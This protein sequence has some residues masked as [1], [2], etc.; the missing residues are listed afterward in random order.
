[1]LFIADPVYTSKTKIVSSTMRGNASQL[2]GL[3]SQIGLNI[4]LGQQDQNYVYE[5]IIKSRQIA[6]KILV[7]NFKTEKFGQ[8]ISLLQLITYGDDEPEFSK[9][10]LL[11]L[12]IEKFLLEMINVSKDIQTGIHTISVNSFEPK[13]SFEIAKSITD[14]LQKHQHEYNKTITSKTR[15]FIEDRIVETKAE[16]EKAEEKLKD[17]RQQNRRIEN[18]FLLQMEEERLSREVTVLIG[19]FTTLKQQLE[20]A[21]IE[22]VRESDYIIVVDPPFV[23][24]LRSSP[25]RKKA[26]ITSFILSFGFSFIL[27]LL[28][29]YFDTFLVNE[30]KKIFRGLSYLSKNFPLFQNII[31]SLTEKIYQNEKRL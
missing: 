10:T 18:S 8:D 23:P 6:E 7:K 30:K 27:V 21:K 11:F 14:E 2:S 4:Q 5:D 17:F 20:T 12:G 22:E 28:K 19:V 9:D 25:K 1:M 26:V 29:N 24:V 16:L 15:N 3:A 31:K 13:L